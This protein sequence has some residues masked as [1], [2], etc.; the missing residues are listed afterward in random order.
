MTDIT[1]FARRMMRIYEKPT[2]TN[3]PR[4]IFGSI[5]DLPQSIASR[6]PYRIGLW[7]CLSADN[8]E[9]AM[10][11]WS[12]LA[13]LLERWRDIQV[14]RIF[15]KFE[16]GADTFDW[17][18]QQSQF[19]VD[20]WSVEPLDE[21]IAIW[22]KLEKTGEIWNLHISIEN[23]LLT[24]QDNEL[25]ELSFT[26][27]RLADFVGQLPKIV[28]TIAKDK[29]EAERLDETASLFKTDNLPDEAVL[30]PFLAK[31]L[32]WDVQLLSNLWGIEVEDATVEALF[33]ELLATGQAV[34]HDVAVWSVSQAV[35]H[36]MAPGYMVIGELFAPRVNEVIEAFPTSDLPAPILATAI[37]TMGN[38]QEA[39]TLLEDDIKAHPDS[40]AGWLK[41][42][43]LYAAGGRI[44]ESLETFQNAIEKEVTSSHLYRAYGNLLLAAEQYGEEVEAYVLIDP[45]DFDEHEIIWE[46]IEAYKKA[47][48]LAPTDIR[49]L[50]TKLLQ[51]LY[52]EAEEKQIWQD[53]KQLLQLDTTGDY[54]RDV[55]ESMYDLEDIQPGVNA[56]KAMLKE[57]SER[58]DVLINLASLYLVTDEG[59][60]AKVYLE[61][62][63]SK[64]AS[65]DKLADIELL[66]L[67][68][69]DPEF[70][71]RFG[72]IEAIVNAGNNP[73]A[74]DVEFLENA[75]E[76]AP[77]VI[78]AHLVLARAYDIWGEKD[79]ALEV[80]LDLQEKLPD[81]PAVIDMLAKLLWDLD[82]KELAFSY[83][84][85]GLVAY[86]FNVPL[87]VRT[88]RYLF[89]NEQWAEARAY[90]GR[91][92]EIAPQDATLQA[93]RGY[94]ARKL[95]ENP[96]LARNMTDADKNS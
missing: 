8:P 29:I 48:Q 26:A 72:E 81:N 95:A 12:I 42:A 93:T 34:N 37:F 52:V 23:D 27:N 50:Y 85:K 44:D 33:E 53:F 13:H 61:Q 60:Q 63:K 79:D 36:S 70:E 76:Q 35:A 39:H 62:A 55:I 82:E 10:G 11:L 5:G 87:L 71:Q 17:S 92:E 28:E 40:V 6:P 64:T 69:D 22:G 66:V 38:V 56:L 16:D 83:L 32:E 59:E 1:T 67:A 89:D 51:L 68:A 75:T 46:A 4:A 47:L 3:T 31:L 84:N 2:A 19:E 73:T 9:F 96:E 14:Y 43:E 90:L 30:T 57:Q 21:N 78:S 49:A 80:L 86:P 15:V 77:H 7:S 94:I 58:V 65:V 54:V 74:D 41:L 91:A 45:D 18:I 88:G 25:I 20:D 24:G